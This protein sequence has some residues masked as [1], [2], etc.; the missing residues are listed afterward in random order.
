MHVELLSFFTVSVALN[1]AY[2][3]RE[4][5][6]DDNADNAN[7]THSRTGFCYFLQ[8]LGRN[9]IRPIEQELNEN[10]NLVGEI[11]RKLELL[12]QSF[13]SSNSVKK[14]VQETESILEQETKSKKEVPE[15][16]SSAA[17]G[18]KPSQDVIHTSVSDRNSV[19]S[20]AAWDES[21]KRQNLSAG[22][23]VSNVQDPMVRK[24][25][26]NLDII[27]SKINKLQP[28]IDGLVALKNRQ[29]EIHE[30]TSRLI[31][32]SSAC[33]L[34]GLYALLVLFYAPLVKKNFIAEVWANSYFVCAD[35][36]C[37]MF[38]LG[39][40]LWDYSLSA[41]KDRAT[42][43]WVSRKI[44]CL[45]EPKRRL[46]IRFF[47]VLLIVAV[48]FCLLDRF[49][50]EQWVNNPL[51]N[52]TYILTSFICYST[53]IVYFLYYFC[54]SAYARL[55]GE[56]MLDYYMDKLD[57]EDFEGTLKSI[58]EEADLMRHIGVEAGDFGN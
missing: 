13:E 8:L 16:T 40:V 45:P 21:G 7:D 39:C 23:E 48:G 53:F 33:L 18:E 15:A 37:F 24:R 42:N 22:A 17:K 27:A 46:A 30:K 4:T 2:V 10:I 55:R 52:H 12:K 14:S 3:I 58:N 54:R 36:I 19:Q 32:I 9:K 31:Y 6:G 50:N 26:D 20:D 38:L 11:K 51:L 57:E 25:Q 35:C 41:Q 1:L 28:C 34:I 47:V 29:L 5:V 56:I 43:V 49:G 44:Q